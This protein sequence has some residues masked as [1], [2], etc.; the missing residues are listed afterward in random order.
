[1]SARVATP[2]VY[3]VLTGQ[4]ERLNVQ[5]V[6]AGSNVPFI[7]LTD[8]PQLRRDDWEIRLVPPMFPG[9]PVRSQRDMKVRPHLYLPDYSVSLYIDNTVLLEEA[10]ERIF[11]VYSIESGMAV[12]HH[13][14]RQSLLDEFVA[15]ARAGLDEPM[16]VFEQLNQ[17]SLEAPEV[18]DTKPHWCGLMLRDHEHPTVRAMEEIWSAQIFRYS[19]RDQLSLNYAMARSGLKPLVME[20]DNHNSWFHRW[21]FS[22]GRAPVPAQPASA[23]ALRP[24]G[25]RIRELELEVR[26]LTRA[27]EALKA[28]AAEGPKP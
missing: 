6:R 16:R 11:A 23:A 22:A 25:A 12:P 24:L 3:T 21:A 20:I 2:C 17:Y 28:A 4:Y 8:D 26:Q 13:S 5:R 14:Y 27:N 18:L 19:R 9:D 7:C 15:V 1:M 10:P